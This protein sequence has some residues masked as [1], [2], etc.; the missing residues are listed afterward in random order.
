MLALLRGP[1]HAVERRRR[2]QADEDGAAL[3]A[4]DQIERRVFVL[5][6]LRE[7]LCAALAR[8]DAGAAGLAAAVEPHLAAAAPVV[9][10]NRIPGPDP[11]ANP[12][13][14]RTGGGGD[15]GGQDGGGIGG[16]SD[17]VGGGAAGGGGEQG[18]SNGAPPQHA[19]DDRQASTLAA[20]KPACGGGRDY[21]RVGS[22]LLSLSPSPALCD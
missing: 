12:D 16:A 5:G 22:Q 7:R 8:V 18:G 14:G 4:S 11:G 19:Q 3:T 13:P 20:A 2:R 21:L 9:A 15:G 10:T 17:G 6:M 1:R